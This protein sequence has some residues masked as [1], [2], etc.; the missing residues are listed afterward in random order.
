MDINGKINS[1]INEFIKKEEFLLKNDLNERTITHKFAEFLNNEE[2]FSWYSIDCEYNRMH[3]SSVKEYITKK[4]NLEFEGTNSDDNNLTTVYP[5]IIVHKR[6]DNSDNLLIIEIKKKEYA[7][8]IKDE[9]KTYR[10]FDY[11]KIELYIDQLSYKNWLYIEFNW[12]E[13]PFIKWF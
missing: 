6:W 12:L 11:E 5:D 10:D 8:R 7:D 3:K 2:L 13:K 9:N 4:L 1:L